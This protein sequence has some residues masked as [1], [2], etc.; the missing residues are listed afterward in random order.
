MPRFAALYRDYIDAEKRNGNFELRTWE[1]RSD[2]YSDAIADIVMSQKQAKLFGH[3]LIQE[4]G[5]NAE[6][7]KP[8][9]DHEEVDRYVAAIEA[10]GYLVDLK[11]E[12]SSVAE[13]KGR[14]GVTRTHTLPA[15]WLAM[16]VEEP[17]TR[18]MGLPAGEGATIL[19]ALKALV[20]IVEGQRS[21]QKE[22]L[23]LA[24]GVE[25]NHL[26]QEVT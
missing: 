3:W 4:T 9:L 10:K 21:S 1:H 8:L 2:N 7:K 26:G 17:P 5:G 22:R 6:V 24:D 19:D 11:H 12:P 15:V 13:R 14:A 20:G 18:G 23:L 16:A 25:R